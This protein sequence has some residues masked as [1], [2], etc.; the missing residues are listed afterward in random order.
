M[1]IGM[2]SDSINFPNLPLM[3]LSSYH[4]EQGD[5]VELIKEGEHYDKVYLSKVFN[6]PL[7]SKIPQSPPMFHADEVIRGGTGYAIK[8]EGGKE[9]FHRELHENLPVEIEHRYPDYSLFPQYQNTAYGFLTRGCCNDCSFCIVCPKEGSQSIQVADLSEF[10]NGQR[11]IK[12]LDPNLLACRNR[13]TLLNELIESGASVDFTQGIDA[14]FIT[15]DIARLINQVKIKTIHFAFDFMKNEKAIIRGLECFKK[16]Y[17][18]SDRNIRCY[19]LT[20]YDTSHEEDWYRV[21]SLTELGYQPYVMIYQ[22]GTHD[23]FLTDLARWSNS[24]FLNRAVSFEDYVPRKDGKSC[25]ELYP[26][27][28]NKKEIIAMP[29]KTEKT[30]APAVDYSGMNICR[31]LQ[32]ARLKFLQAGVKKTGKNIHLEFMYFELADIVPVAEAIFTEV[33]LLMVP[34]FGKEYAVAKVFNCDDRDEEPMTFEAPF[35]Q[36]APIVSN[37]GKVV[38]NEMQALGSSLTYMR[39]YLWQLV[40]DIIEA[41]S[42]DNTSGVGENTPTPPPTPKPTRKAPVTP[43][44]RKKIKTELTSAPEGAAS[45]EQ[46]ATL[47]AELKKL[48]ELDAEQESFVQNVTVKTEGFTK[49][50]AD[51]CDQLISGVREM[52]AAYDTQEG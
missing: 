30:P 15:D 32:I 24:L 23:R 36:I 28:L 10:W 13:E 6:L 26:E 41:D 12:L 1:K 16:H 31:K 20:N 37:S 29:V 9:V 11:E 21:R 45:E 50:T 47:K 8:V 5:S 27:I 17:R 43:E 38:T 48:M 46:V 49:I 34:T 39:R 25:R 51:V 52:L 22:K 40:L 14:R 42:I 7:L 35:T 18:G 19:V 3:K 2:W 4:K 44:Q 33:G